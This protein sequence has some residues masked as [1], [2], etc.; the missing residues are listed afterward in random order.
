MQPEFICIG[1]QKCGTTTLYDL[2]RQHQGIVL[3]NDVKEPMVYRQ[4]FFY[5]HLGGK[6]WYE[7][8]YFS[9]VSEGDPRLR[10]EVNA[11]LG[12]KGCAQ[13]IGQDYP[14]ETKLIFMM[15]SPADRA[16]SAYK[17]FLALGFLPAA[18]ME[19]DKRHGHAA[20][21]D[22]YARFTLKYVGH[23][24]IMNHRQRYLVFSQGNYATLIQEYLEYFP[25]KN[26]HFILFEEFVDH[27]KE[28]CRKLYSFLGID[29]DPAV[30]YG[31][32][33][34]EGNFRARNTFWARLGVSDMGCYYTGYE[35][36]DLSRRAPR[37]YEKYRTKVHEPIQRKCVVPET[38]TGKMLPQT[39]K[40]LEEYY[41]PQVKGVERIL[42]RSLSG[43]W[44]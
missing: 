12:M 24:K 28:A 26:M 8:R 17:Y 13:R 19:D 40:L 1:F 38:D 44:Y 3:T 9:H 37:F 33:S 41:R 16:Y 7:K 18:A 31:L 11:G 10:G 43:L 21:F 27:Q 29:E 23:E 25:K 15:R 30:Q 32:K 22:R 35:F 42:D 36:W 34:N 20:A 6:E 4:P 2:L 39:R 5:K 14:T